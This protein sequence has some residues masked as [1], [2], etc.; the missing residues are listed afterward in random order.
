MTPPND[1]L[2][3]GGHRWSLALGGALGTGDAAASLA[4][5]DALASRLGVRLPE[6]Y[7]DLAPLIQGL[8]PERAAF[9]VWDPLPEQHVDAD[10]FPDLGVGCIRNLGAFVLL[11]ADGEPHRWSTT[12]AAQIGLLERTAPGLLPI[13][14]D[15]RG[16]LVC[17]DYGEDWTDDAPTVTYYDRARQA[18]DDVLPV[19][20]SFQEFLEG[21]MADEDGLGTGQGPAG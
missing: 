15:L 1:T 10:G 17:L 5:L 11:D 3:A 8:C 13:A 20:P 18:G 19:A 2:E 16:N 12:V 4:S 7:R 9:V 14:L 21:L 6:R